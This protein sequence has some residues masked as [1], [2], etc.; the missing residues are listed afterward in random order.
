V[1]KLVPDTPHATKRLRPMPLRADIA[2]A[3]SGDSI[4]FAKKL[5]GRTITLASGEL[6]ITKSLSIDELGADQLTIS[7]THA[8]RI[9]RSLVRIRTSPTL[10]PAACN[11]E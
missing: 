11:K 8:N 2:A 6:A 5:K 10:Q 4:E 3:P 1:E 7:G 9:G